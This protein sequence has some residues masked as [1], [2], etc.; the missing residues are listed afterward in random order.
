MK[1]QPDKI[2]DKKKLA[3]KAIQRWE[4]EGGEVPEI[5]SLNTTIAIEERQN[6]ENENQHTA[7][8]SDSS[9][10]SKDSAKSVIA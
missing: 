5:A 6:A 1:K 4:N 7:E 2:D 10:C 8:V 3:E 9:F